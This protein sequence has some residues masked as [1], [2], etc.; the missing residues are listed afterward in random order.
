MRL[1]ALRGAVVVALGLG[2]AASASA[3]TTGISLAI[4]PTARANGMGQAYVA[5]ADDAT[6]TWW[7]PAGLAFLNRKDASI[8]HS[9]LAAGLADDVFYEYPTFILPVKDWG[10]F[11]ASVVYL[12]YGTSTAT[13]ETGEVLEDFTSYE[14]APTV[15]YGTKLTDRFGV[16]VNF[17]YIRAQYAPQLSTL[18]DAGRGSTVAADLGLLYKVPGDMVN[19]GVN[20][21]NLGPDITFISDENREPIFRNLRAGVAVNAYQKEEFQV[22]AVGDVNQVLVRGENQDTGEKKFPKAIFN[23]GGEVSYGG[24]VAV[25]GGYVYDSE[26]LIKDATYGVGLMYKGLRFDFASIPQSK[27]LPRVERFSLAYR[28]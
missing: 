3:Q 2:L 27:E 11:G 12:N 5:L 19:V 18:P 26:G 25:R 10:V 14:I 17:K 20:V 7:N 13:S 15:S 24:L 23:G 6:A 4:Q 22:V 1:L 21:Q 8:T 16:G 9:A 28:F